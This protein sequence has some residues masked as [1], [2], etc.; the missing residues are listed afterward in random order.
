[1]TKQHQ[2]WLP[3]WTILIGV[4]LFIAWIV[5]LFLDAKKQ[6]LP[7]Q[8][9]LYS[10]G[11]QTWAWDIRHEPLSWELQDTEL[12]ASSASKQEHDI[13]LLDEENEISEDILTPLKEKITFLEWEYERE[14]NFKWGS[15]LLEAYLLDHQY[16]QAKKSFE[17]FPQAVK[18][19]F[20]ADSYFKI[21]LKSISPTEEKEYWLLKRYFQSLQAQNIFTP[22]EHNYYQSLFAIV[23]G[24]Y[25]ELR[26]TL[27]E[28][29]HTQYQSY[30]QQITSAFAQYEQMQDVP[31]YY[32]QGLLA[33]QLMQEG[34][35][36]LAKKLAI[37]LVNSYP[38]YILPYQVLAN[39]D[40]VLGKYESSLAYFEQLLKIDYQQ[41]NNYLYHLGILNYQLWNFTEAVLYFSQ[42]TDQNLMLDGDR[43][44]V[45]SYLALQ[46][47]EKALKSW[48]RLLG[49]PQIKKS[50]F[51]SFFEEAVWKPYRRWEVSWYL[52]KD[53]KLVQNYLKL[54]EKKLKN[55]DQHTCQ[56]GKVGIQIHQSPST[57]AWLFKQVAPLAK[58]Y[59]QAGLYQVLW[60]IA[61]ENQQ[62]STATEWYMKA[63]ALSEERVEKT[64][65][66]DKIIDINRLD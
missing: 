37:P 5:F 26:A 2:N 9:E 29:S 35:Y 21:L 53:P 6:R 22:E 8:V 13:F 48:K 61:V 46:D 7:Q 44:L 47:D 36:A 40:F 54:C 50:D 25:E 23:E 38:N 24:K 3:I 64:L 17:A 19:E 4:I 62:I 15:L 66:K 51:F 20:S 55:T 43:Y 12:P 57:K 14:K 18:K 49:Q 11:V 31:A 1:M 58:K 65:L 59:P 34:Q 42:I 30:A 10:W 56:Y 63:L 39:T 27:A 60:D 16:L 32:Q 33:F 41:K 52:S 28:L 45:L